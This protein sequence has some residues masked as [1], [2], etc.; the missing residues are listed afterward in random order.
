MELRRLYRILLIGLIVSILWGY[1]ECDRS[2]KALVFYDLGYTDVETAQIIFF[3]TVA[4][5][6]VEIIGSVLIFL[7][8]YQLGKDYKLT[9]SSSITFISI[10]VCMV[11]TGNFLG[12]IVRLIQVPQ[13]QPWIISALR[14]FLLDILW[15]SPSLILW[16]FTGLLVSNYIRELNRA[17]D[18]P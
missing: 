18:V 10:L 13:Y 17:D 5:W 2:N 9:M 12:L 11:L 6:L 16:S 7:A 1:W 3:I 4:L 8:S 15:H 14:Y